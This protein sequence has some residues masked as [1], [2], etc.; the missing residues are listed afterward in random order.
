MRR[1]IGGRG[2]VVGVLLLVLLAG[3][4]GCTAPGS[5]QAATAT[6]AQPDR[7]AVWRELIRCVRANGMPNLP[8]PQFDQSGEPQFPGGNPAEPP[9]RARRACEHIHNRLP[10]SPRREETQTTADAPTLL[11]FGRCMREHGL[12]DFPDPGSDGVFRLGG[13]NARRELYGV[14]AQKGPQSPRAV[15]AME[16]CGMNGDLR[17]KIFLDVG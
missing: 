13:T 16:A 11:R 8:D 5:S 2:A 3:L 1:F 14:G 4:G 9:E 6:T 7:V 10:P 17:G 12:A 15:A